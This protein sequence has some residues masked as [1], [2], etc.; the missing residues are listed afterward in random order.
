MYNFITELTARQK[1]DE[2]YV[3][4]YQFQED[5][6]NRYEGV[7]TVS[8]A[9][10]RANPSIPIAYNQHTIMSFEAITALEGYQPLSYE[11]RPIRIN[12]SFERALLERLIK[13]SFLIA[14]QQCRCF[15]RRGYD[16]YVKERQIAQTR[17]VYI[18][19]V[20]MLHVNIVD[21][22]ICIG[23]HLTH[24][25]E[26]KKTVQ[27]LLN[28]GQRINRGM[29]LMHQ[30]YTYTAEQLADYSVMDLCPLLNMSIYDYYMRR[31]QT[32]ITNTFHERINVVHVRANGNV[33]SYAANLLKPVCS[34]D[35]MTPQEANDV[36]KLIKMVPNKRMHETFTYMKVLHQAHRYLTFPNHP[37]LIEQNGYAY[38]TLEDPRIFF[39]DEYT[40][41]QKGMRYGKLYRAGAA[42]ISVFLDET[43][44]HIGDIPRE[45]IHQFVF[46]LQDIAKKH[47]VNININPATAQVK[48]KFTNHFFEKFSTEIKQLHDTFKHTTVLAFITEKHLSAMPTNIYHAFKQQF[49]GEWDI[50]SQ[51]VTE[52][53]LSDFNKLIKGLREPTREAIVNRVLSDK[54]RYNVFN[55]LLG[56]Y[57]KSG[58]QPW[59]LAQ[60]THSD[61]FIGLDVSHEHG[62]SAAGMVNVI[63]NRGHLIKQSSLHGRLTGEKI[64][65]TL[66]TKLLEDVLSSYKAQFHT[67]PRHLTIHRDGFWREQ[68]ATI[69]ALLTHYGIAYDIVE[70]IKKPNRRMAYYD[71]QQKCFKTAQG[72][73]YIRGNEALL[74]ATNP[75]EKIGMAQAIKI[76]QV[77]NHLS[78]KQIIEDVYHLSFMHI[79]AMNKMRLPA[80]I[81]YA[82]LSATA[83]QRG[84]ILP[85]SKNQTSLPF[86]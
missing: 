53:T 79:H 9:W 1:A 28:N 47:G 46:M 68:T 69:D 38:E 14:A 24:K 34:F 16:L 49:G 63:G 59:I 54:L 58:L 44:I 70:I 5:E 41:V 55:I 42:K 56:L 52:K 19:K 76:H 25:F 6:A 21:H 23:F 20:L 43:M 29:K 37:F 45:G 48:G 12:S 71:M 18:F 35:T 65:D 11:H 80:T 3:H 83:Y 26:Y 78:F 32:W 30:H 39:E 27:D 61:C 60:P 64:D 33:L 10:Q 57:V 22:R 77:T 8:R 15:E 36:N 73:C 85:Q 40:S 74:C 66:L 86:V 31:G 4:I 13:H 72:A 50:S 84:E 7:Y 62:N 82:D 17:S 75:A 67:Y 2:L 81:H 51:I